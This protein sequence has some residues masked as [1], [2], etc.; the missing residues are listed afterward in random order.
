MQLIT[1]ITLSS[2]MQ[3]IL[4][5]FLLPCSEELKN[6]GKYWHISY[7][8]RQIIGIGKCEKIHISATL[9]LLV[10]VHEY[11]HIDGSYM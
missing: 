2:Q 8:N 6:I 5:L 10:Y 9:I 1:L 11:V 3:F 7:R 4:Y